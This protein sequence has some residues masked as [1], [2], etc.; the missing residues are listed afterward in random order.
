MQIEEQKKKDIQTD[1][2]IRS[3]VVSGEELLRLLRVLDDGVNVI[4]VGNGL[5][6]FLVLVTIEPALLLGLLNHLIVLFHQGPSQRRLVVLPHRRITQ[7]T[8][9][10]VGRCSNSKEK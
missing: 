10:W 4:D 5:E 6:N 9:Q 1:R 3:K 8:A 7:S 2:H